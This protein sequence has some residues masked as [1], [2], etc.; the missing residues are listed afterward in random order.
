MAEIVVRYA[1][2]MQKM[3]DYGYAVGDAVGDVNDTHC[4]TWILTQRS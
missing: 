1:D 4:R 2:T 3:H